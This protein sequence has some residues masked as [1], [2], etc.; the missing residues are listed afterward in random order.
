MS[1]PQNPKLALASFL[2]TVGTER[3]LRLYQIMTS[4]DD[5]V[6]ESSKATMEG[7]S[8]KGVG[9]VAK[10]LESIGDKGMEEV[11]K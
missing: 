8:F 6:L 2:P 1:R 11:H 10:T 3:F 4:F 5:R 7:F 9:I